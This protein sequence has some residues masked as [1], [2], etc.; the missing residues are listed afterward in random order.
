MNLRQDLIIITVFLFKITCIQQTNNNA[1][2]FIA[3]L[4]KVLAPLFLCVFINKYLY[5]LPF[6]RKITAGTVLIKLTEDFIFKE[7]HLSGVK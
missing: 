1:L 5:S 3:E 4:F 6:F 7:R 2:K